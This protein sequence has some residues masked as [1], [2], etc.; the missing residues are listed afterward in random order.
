[1]NIINMPGFT[2]DKSL[3]NSGKK[4]NMPRA[5]TKR[6]SA[7]VVPQMK[8]ECTRRCQLKCNSYFCWWTNCYDLCF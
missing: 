8:V 5:A 6:S 2:A 4:Y 7:A 3:Y 1:M